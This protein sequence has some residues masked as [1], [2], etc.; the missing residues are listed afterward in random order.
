MSALCE[1]FPQAL[2]TKTIACLCVLKFLSD[3][4][5]TC[6][7]KS[8]HTQVA[9]KSDFKFGT[10]S[11]I[12]MRCQLLHKRQMQAIQYFLAKITLSVNTCAISSTRV[13][14]FLI[15][16]RKNLQIEWGFGD[17]SIMITNM[18]WLRTI[19]DFAVLNECITC[20]ISMKWFFL[21]NWWII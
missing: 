15:I 16:V 10:I 5:G 6:V 12:F 8:D 20:F 7:D 17:A 9:F 3:T 4:R 18:P 2:F 11:M 14:Q 21:C 19:K 13:V 1:N